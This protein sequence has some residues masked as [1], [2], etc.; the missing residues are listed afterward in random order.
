LNRLGDIEHGMESASGVR[1][2]IPQSRR[3][4]PG[5]RELLDL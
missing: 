4:L 5:A 1:K 3:K 2:T